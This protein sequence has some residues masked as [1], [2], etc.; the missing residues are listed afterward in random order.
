MKFP[1]FFFS[2]LISSEKDCVYKLGQEFQTRIYDNIF[3]IDK[4]EMLI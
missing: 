4:E 1:F 2:F 3:K